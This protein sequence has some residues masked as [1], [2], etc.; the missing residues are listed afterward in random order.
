SWSMG[1]WAAEVSTDE[2]GPAIRGSAP[3][4][5]WLPQ[6]TPTTK[7]SPPHE[8]GLN[9]IRSPRGESPEGRDNLAS[10]SSNGQS[11]GHE[12]Y[13]LG[14]QKDREDRLPLCPAPSM[15]YISPFTFLGRRVGGEG[16]TFPLVPWREGRRKGYVMGRMVSGGKKIGIA[17][18]VLL[19][20]LAGAG[21]AWMQRARLLAWYYIYRL[22]Q[23]D[24]PSRTA[25]AERV[26]GLETGAPT[27]LLTCLT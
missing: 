9:P 13:C 5:A 7:L 20:I 12:G 2:R 10:Y 17:G 3:G 19:I 4:V 1:T 16:K 25:W 21:A 8:Y 11:T 23:A 14:H 6:R 22:T 24:D 15:A 27:R 26:A 18:L